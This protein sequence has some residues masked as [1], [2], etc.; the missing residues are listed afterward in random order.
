M[1][2]GDISV[3]LL[4]ELQM[5]YQDELERLRAS[6]PLL[7]LCFPTCHTDTANLDIRTPLGEDGWFD[8][9]PKECL[10][11]TGK[12]IPIRKS[13]TPHCG[14]SGALSLCLTGHRDGLSLFSSTPISQVLI[15]STRV[16]DPALRLDTALAM[17]PIGKR[18]LP[19]PWTCG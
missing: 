9:V 6:F 8:S 18:D 1:N 2:Y 11:P 12:A 16:S 3:C 4:C 13:P 15:S 14:S 17:T 10:V 5:R 19:V 7:C